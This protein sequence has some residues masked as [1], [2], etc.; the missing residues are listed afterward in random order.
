M[1]NLVILRI[2][3]HKLDPNA[4]HRIDDNDETGED[5][6]DGGVFEGGCTS[7]RLSV[8]VPKVANNKL[9]FVYAD[10]HFDLYVG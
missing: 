9:F 1:G 5:D 7:P 2:F 6:P 4:N 3:G 8:F 10:E